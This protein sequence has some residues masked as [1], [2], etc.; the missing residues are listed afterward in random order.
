MQG[1]SAERPS[2]SGVGRIQPM[3]GLVDGFFV[4]A[5]NSA[6]VESWKGLWQ[7]LKGRDG[8]LDRPDAK[9]FLEVTAE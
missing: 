5:N 1:V 4:P 2:V 8:Q 7:R 9:G 6:V 3:S